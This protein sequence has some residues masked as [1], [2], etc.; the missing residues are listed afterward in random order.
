M[1][2]AC[3]DAALDVGNVVGAG[4]GDCEAVPAAKYL[5][6]DSLAL[7]GGAAVAGRGNCHAKECKGDED[8]EL[9]K[10]VH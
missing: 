2:A 3:F 9:H 6:A 8:G 10:L 4:T 5:L 1:M 7:G